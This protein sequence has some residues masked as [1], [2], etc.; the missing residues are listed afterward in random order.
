MMADGTSRVSPRFRARMAGVCYLLGSLTSVLGQMVI[1][2]RFEVTGNAA[3]TSANILAHPSLFRLG[4][5]L[6]LMTVPFHAAWAVLF[7]G[8]FRPVSRSLSALAAYILLMGCAMWAL[9]SLFQLAPLLVLQ[10][11]SSLS[12]FAPEQLQAMAYL[13]IKLNAQAYDMGLV[14]FGFW[15]IL[16]GILIAQSS[17]LP[18]AIGVLGI[19]AGVGYL[20]LIW[21]PLAHYLYPYNLALAGPGE[22]S[23]MFW[24]LV[25]GVDDRKWEE[26]A[27]ARVD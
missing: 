27:A 2:G 9:S 10:N 18:R 26:A 23:L 19:I 22:I 7:Q 16:I 25:K 1:L 12:A 15:Y 21:R 13:F 24:L 20:T 5:A 17:F 8:L 3:A 4:F 11:K 14:F 6:S